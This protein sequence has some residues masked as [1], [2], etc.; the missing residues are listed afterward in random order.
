MQSGITFDSD[1]GS[2]SNPLYTTTLTLDALGR[3]KSAV[4][5]DGLPK[6]VS[7][8]LDGAGQIV[9]HDESRNS[10]PSAAAPHEV[11]YRFAGHQIGMIGNDGAGGNAG[12][13]GYAQSVAERSRAAVAVTA[14]NAGLF[15]DGTS[16]GSAAAFDFAQ[17][18]EA[19]NAYQQ[20]SGS[21][22]Y[23]VQGGETLGGIAQAVW[24]DASLWYKLAEA[25]GLTLNSPLLA[26]QQLRLPAGVNRSHYNAST[27]KPY[28]PTDASG[29]LSPTSPKPPK[30]PKCGVLGQILLTVIAVAVTYFTAGAA[31][32]TL[33]PVL[34]GAAA[35]AA[36]SI[37]S[38]AVGLATGIQSKFSFKG[39]ALAAV[40]GAVGGGL[41][42]ADAFAKLGIAGNLIGAL[43]AQGAL[44]GTIT[45]GIGVATGLQSKF[46]F[47][48]VAASAA[49]S[50]AGGKFGGL[51]KGG[52]FAS[53]V[54]NDIA[55]ASAS[56]FANA[57]T[58]SALSG[59]NFGNNLIAALPDAIGG[60]LGRALGEHSPRSDGEPRKA[61]HRVL[62]AAS[63]EHLPLRSPREPQREPRPAPYAKRLAQLPAAAQ[64]RRTRPW[65]TRLS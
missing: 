49:G 39:V 21:G 24:G 33:G 22:A 42:A 28:D 8:V 60:V 38:Q 6:S 16:T 31:T 48:G 58:R 7:Y 53:A 12:M 59:T 1:T 5:A 46:D 43:A 57:A 50:V 34:G 51:F 36:G 26:G 2:G 64:L 55:S 45:Q 47:V 14:S 25:N 62:R 20:G 4:V 23:T 19:I 52:F 9:R 18:S 17:S 3:A 32:A 56:L 30:K 40:G 63:R 41:K 10:N 27:F 65:A 37:A 44:T 29:N 54:G 61:R 13:V 35:G 11:F 15:R